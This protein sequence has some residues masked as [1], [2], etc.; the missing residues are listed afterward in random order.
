MPEPLS[1]SEILQVLFTHSLRA[2]GTPYKAADV[3][4]ATGVSPAQISLL[5]SGQRTST[6]IEI[7]R[8]LL[9]F[10]KVSLDILNVTSTQQAQEFIIACRPEHQPTIRL[11]GT[12]GQELSTAA[13]QQIEQL[14]EYVLQREY[15]TRTG[16]SLPSLPHLDEQRD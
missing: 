15:A 6:S 1:F 12:L 8:S 16:Q 13:L 3:A 14:I 9:G 10:F 2:D 11:R 5:L 4:R 7:A